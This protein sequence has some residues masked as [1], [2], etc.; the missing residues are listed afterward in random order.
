MRSIVKEA[1]EEPTGRE[2]LAKY[3]YDIMTPIAILAA[4]Q[5]SF[6]LYFY[7]QGKSVKMEQYLLG[8]S[9]AI[10]FYSMFYWLLVRLRPESI[11]EE[12]EKDFFHKATSVASVIA[13][14]ILTIDLVGM[15]VYLWYKFPY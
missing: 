6:L 13:G 15:I 12:H 11:M 2:K 3:F 9:L 1:K 14:L 10:L 5:A 4:I 8:L 7:D